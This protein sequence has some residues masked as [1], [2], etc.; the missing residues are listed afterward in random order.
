MLKKSD[1]QP[2][3][4][5]EHLE[6]SEQGFLVLDRDPANRV[7]RATEEFDEDERAT[8]VRAL[9][10]VI[11]AGVDMAQG[12]G[13]AL[14]AQLL[15]LPGAATCLWLRS[16]IGEATNPRLAPALSEGRYG[17]VK[18]RPRAGSVPGWLSPIAKAT[19]AASGFTATMKR[20]VGS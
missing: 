12:T 7:A 19:R 18:N 8:I 5:P 9:R 6:L 14:A 17:L 11:K 4:R 15:F 3:G 20:F 2:S 10:L 1:Y 13:K 16:Y